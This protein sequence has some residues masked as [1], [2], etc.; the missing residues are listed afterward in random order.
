MFQIAYARKLSLELE[1]EI[2]IDY[3][4]Y[5]N[6]KIRDFSLSNLEVSNH[7]KLLDTSDL[8]LFENYRYKITQ[9][10]YHVFQKI[11]KIIRGYDRI[12]KKAF[13]LLSKRGLYYNFDVYYYNHFGSNKDLKYMYG[14]FQSENY[15]IEYKEQIKKDLKVRVEPNTRESILL[16][17]IKSCNAV[18]ISMRLGA[19]YTNS[20]IFNVC[21]PDYYYKGMDYIFS[22]NKD[23]VFYIFSDDIKKAKEQFNFQYPVKYIEGFKDYESLRLMYSCKHFVISNSSFSWWGAYLSSFS[24]KIVVAPSKWYNNSKIKPDIYMDKMT[25]IDV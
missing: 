23:A 1:E 4:V 22:K 11:I 7:Y 14:Y 18:S 16:D 5:E 6:Y 10:M 9:K 21:T 19:D 2:Y 20:S 3:S 24:N 8:S 17:E 12:G 13:N 25:L 15:F